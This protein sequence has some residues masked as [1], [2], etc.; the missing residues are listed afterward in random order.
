ML[1]FDFTGRT[2]LITG[3]TRGIGLQLASE[4]E[5]LGASLLLTGTN[6]DKIEELNQTNNENSKRTYLCADFSDA[7]S[8]R[9]LCDAML[10]KKI[11]VLVNNAAWNR[12]NFLEKAATEDFDDIV[13]ICF[14][15]PW[16]LMRAIG[17]E[18]KK[19]GY[20]RIVNIASVLG[21]GVSFPGRSIYSGVKS[22]LIG[23]T[24]SV[25]LELAPDVLVNSVSPGF[26]DTEMT[27]T[28]LTP[29]KIAD[30]E[31]QVPLGRLALTK[32]IAPVV[33]YLASD[34]NTFITGKNIV[35]DGGYTNA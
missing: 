6:P 34:L 29:D 9:R 23:M 26:V 25:A 28:T 11:D 30:L 15:A 2:V 1:E 4:F 3:A 21:S 5:E 32:D 24:G 16:L 18:M 10:K 14:K 7:E 20:G 17:P 13:N 8:T 27:R 19:R 22:G 33:V 31:R 12:N 35:T